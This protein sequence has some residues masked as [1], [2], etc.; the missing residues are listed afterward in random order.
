MMDKLQ[1][2]LCMGLVG[3]VIG[4]SCGCG[5]KSP[6]PAKSI[7][8]PAVVQ[9]MTVYNAMSAD[10]LGVTI[11]KLSPDERTILYGYAILC[12]RLALR[13]VPWAVENIATEKQICEMYIMAAMTHCE[14]PD[15]NK[16][17]L[18]MYRNNAKTPDF[19]F[20]QNVEV[21]DEPLREVW[22]CALQTAED[23]K[24]NEMNDDC[25]G[26]KK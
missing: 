16:L 2:M 18:W 14:C 17:L 11:E 8:P 22:R 10:E 26:L 7:Y 4:W 9:E 6:Q 20:V 1:R 13:L 21:L 23:A 19:S 24:S 12:K 3:A 5:Q 15:K 25:F